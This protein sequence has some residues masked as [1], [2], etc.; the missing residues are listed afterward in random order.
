MLVSISVLILCLIGE[1]DVDVEGN[2]D[3]GVKLILGLDVVGGFGV[4]LHADF[5]R[6]C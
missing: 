6:R 4:G 2:V 3:V 5:D 1:V